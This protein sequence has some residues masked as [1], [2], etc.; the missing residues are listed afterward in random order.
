MINTL[1]L[2]LIKEEEG[3]RLKSYRCGAGVYTIGFGHTSDSF[4]RVSKNSVITKEFADEL[5]YHDLD[6][7]EDTIHE[8]F[9]DWGLLNE[10]QYAAIVSFVYNTG[11]LKLKKYP[12]ED[13]TILTHL[14]N[15][16][17]QKAGDS[18]LIYTKDINGK[19]L[20]GLVKRRK[21]ERELFLTPV[22]KPV[23]A[24]EPIQTSLLKELIN[25]I[26]MFFV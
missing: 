3:L 15:H 20:A 16:D 1:G 9:P 11:S 10:N 2:A 7:A 18:F 21:K 5:L 17:W 22:V 24:I 13:R 12:Y 25:K 19:H 23:I 26:K 8:Q 14:K 4:Y 6:E